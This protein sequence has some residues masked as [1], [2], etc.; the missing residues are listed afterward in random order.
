MTL[1]PLQIAGI[2]TL[3]VGLIIL[4][5]N[6]RSLIKANSSKNWLSAEG[7]ILNSELDITKSFG[8]SDKVYN[9]KVEY[10]YLVNGKEYCSTR[11]YYGSSSSSTFK[12]SKSR[13]IIEKYPKGSRVTV[14]YDPMNE[15]EAVIERGVKPEVISLI[16]ASSVLLACSIYVLTN[17]EFII[18]YFDK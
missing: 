17:F 12:K 5:F 13:N 1:H 4:I 3:I 11:I 9:P 18:K 7:E 6:L 15:S 8:E 10:K 2:I 14:F 16:L